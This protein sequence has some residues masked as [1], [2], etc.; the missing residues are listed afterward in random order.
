[1]CGV[2]TNV[3]TAVEIGEKNSTDSPL[4]PAM[5]ETTARNFRLSEVSADKGYASR[6]H[7]FGTTR[8]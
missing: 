4:L 6:V 1:M 3:V 5:V 2:K 8:P 7:T